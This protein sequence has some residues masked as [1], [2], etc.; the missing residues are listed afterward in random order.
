ME[1][2][3]V[4]AMH[5]LTSLIAF[6]EKELKHLP[7]EKSILTVKRLSHVF[8][9]PEVWGRYNLLLKDVE[10]DV[11]IVEINESEYG[12]F[13]P[14]TVDMRDNS[15]QRILKPVKNMPNLILEDFETLRIIKK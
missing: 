6:N 5:C 15:P 14:F 3:I 12:S 10:I 13:Y 2:Y 9:D 1:Q 8:Y 7:K 11:P 4:N